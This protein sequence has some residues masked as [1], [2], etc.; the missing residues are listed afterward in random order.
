MQ[1]IVFIG[2]NKSGTSREALEY[3][4]NYG[5]LYRSIN[6]QKRI[7]QSKEIEFPEV[8]QMVYVE[9]LM[10]KEMIFSI[11]NNL[12]EDRKQICAVISFIDPF[13]SFAARI[14]KN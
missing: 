14:S 12:E 2:S 10:D 13:V 9:N 7:Y 1:T 11:I 8:H 4:N 5:L 6:E 3:F